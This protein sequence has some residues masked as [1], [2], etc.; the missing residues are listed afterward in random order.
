MGYHA[1]H[2]SNNFILSANMLQPYGFSSNRLK[3]LLDN[4]FCKY[5]QSLFPKCMKESTEYIKLLIEYEANCYSILDDLF[6]FTL[7][8]DHIYHTIY[9]NIKLVLNH[10]YDI[11]MLTEP[12][13]KYFLIKTIGV[14]SGLTL[15]SL[16][17]D[18]LELGPR[19]MSG[20]ETFLL[21]KARGLP[22][23]IVVYIFRYYMA[24]D[25]AKSDAIEERIR[26]LKNFK[27]Y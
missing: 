16:E 7:S 1:N 14:S 12:I 11:K 22:N 13:F 23:D 8:L 6:L 5:V 21:G 19:S 2:S 25:Y 18:S 9:N 24:I 3:I 4:G 17:L 20:S 10:M 15:D 27:K 26:T